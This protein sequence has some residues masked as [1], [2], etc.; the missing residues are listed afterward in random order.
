VRSSTTAFALPR[1]VNNAG[2]VYRMQNDGSWQTPPGAGLDV[3]SGRDFS[4]WIIGLNPVGGGHGL[5]AFNA[6][7][8]NAVSGGGE[9]IAIGPDGS[10]RW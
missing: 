1:V 4:L 2:G 3:A 8:W 9:R 10:R 5:R 6:S 7:G